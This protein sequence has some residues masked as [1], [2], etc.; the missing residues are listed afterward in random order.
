MLKNGTAGEDEIIGGSGADRLYGK[1]GDDEI[2]GRAG[3]D[4]LYGAA[5]EDELYGG[6]GNDRLY[7]GT[8]DDELDGGRGHDRI[9]GGDGNDEIDGG[10]GNDRTYGGNGNDESDADSGNGSLNGGCGRDAREGDEPAALDPRQ[11]AGHR[12]DQRR[13]AG[14]LE[15]RLALGARAPAER[16][17]QVA[18]EV[19]R[20]PVRHEVRGDGRRVRVSNPEDGRVLDHV[21]ADLL[22]PG[23]LLRA[24][25]WS[26]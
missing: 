3:D 24:L 19:A 26:R 4:R 20:R 23:Q 1:G 13:V 6:D 5:G 17:R 10:D 12:L 22:P 21:P 18:H 16:Q 14:R 11:E 8:Q 7:G 9:Y 15:R 25:K 2:K